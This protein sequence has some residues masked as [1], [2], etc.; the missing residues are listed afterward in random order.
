MLMER[1]QAQEL[2]SRFAQRMERGWLGFRLMLTLLM[3]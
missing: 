3:D 2:D 1:L